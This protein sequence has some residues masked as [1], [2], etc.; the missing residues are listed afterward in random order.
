MNLSARILILQSGSALVGGVANYISSILQEPT[1][2]GPQFLVS[3]LPGE[4]KA[5][6]KQKKYG[7]AQLVELRLEYN[8]WTL[9]F[10]AI[11]LFIVIRRERVSFVHAHALRSG[12]ICGVLNFALGTKF[13]YTN[14][15]L[16]FTQ[17]KNRLSRWLFLMAEI[18][19]SRRAT[20]IICVRKTDY[21]LLAILVPRYANKI[22]F[23]ITKIRQPI[24]NSK[25][26]IKSDLI[27]PINLVGVGSI[28]EV[29]RVDIFI[30][31]LHNLSILDVPYRAAWL[32]DGILRTS[33]ENLARDVGVSVEWKGHV[34]AASVN[35][36]L[37]EADLL[38]LTSEFE[39]MPLAA[40]EALAAGTPI[41]T[42]NFFGAGEFVRS[43]ITG[44][45]INSTE[46]QAAS[47]IK[48]LHRNPPQL[49][50]MKINCRKVFQS[51]FCDN[52]GVSS[53][54]LDLYASLVSPS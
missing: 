2:L 12:M 39:V 41:I 48:N 31:W 5:V 52:A 18:W 13:I 21:R 46:D 3:V 1:Q 9:L 38:L 15:G 40:L 26:H 33:M 43:N 14:H 47:R 44:V 50:R 54:Y 24:Q 42:T 29:K 51:R 30:K 8:I 4:S 11:Q 22:K 37:A 28:I 23:L 20:S 6:L 19:V 16:R 49:N 36:E 32:G 25:K 45:I 17:K 27:R 35:R 10:A 34:D 53:F 7:S